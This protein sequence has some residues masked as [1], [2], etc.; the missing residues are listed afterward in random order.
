M[1]E[2]VVWFDSSE[3]G[4]P[5]LNNAAGS[6]I[7]VLDACLVTGFNSK[8]VTSISVLSGVAT[9]TCNG[10]GFSGTYGKDVLISGA[11]PA[12]LNGRKALTF[13]DTNTFRYATVV[14]DGAATGTIT[15][16]R[17]SLGWL[18]QFSGTNKAIYKRSDVTATSIML[19]VLDTAVAPATTTDARVFM[20]ETAT[21]I[22]TYTG[23]GP[24]QAAF[25]DGQCWNKGVNTVTAKQWSVVGDSKGIYLWTQ[26]GTTIMPNSTDAAALAA[27]GDFASLKAGD[28]YNTFLLGLQIV[29][30]TGTPTNPPSFGGINTP[31]ATGD[32][33][34]VIARSYSQLAQSVSAVVLRGVISGTTGYAISP[35]V[36]DSGFVLAGGLPL[37]EGGTQR[38]VRGYVP[39]MY[40]L[41]NR[42]PSSHYVVLSDVVGVGGRKIMTMSF[43]QASGPA[44]CAI[45]ITGPWRQ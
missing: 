15:A 40:D 19:R 2:F 34:F 10:H 41:L 45:D 1:S 43:T 25:A 6:M 20:V 38:A 36:V 29:G 11:T 21:D 35:S 44:Q 16:K 13:V 39:G 33:G 3:A 42:K 14:A 30:Y 27:F 22:D 26:S 28:A 7:S 23:Q 5:V 4:A 24:T 31:D 12:G 18:K 8:S 37:L 9:V 32:V 17:D